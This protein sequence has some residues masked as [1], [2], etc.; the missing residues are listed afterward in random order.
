MTKKDNPL[1]SLVVPCYNVSFFVKKCIDSIKRQTYSNLEVLMIDDGSLDDT[2]KVI[3]ENIQDDKRFKYFYKENG[4]LSDARNYGLDK[5]RGEYISFIDSDDYL[6][7]NYVKKLYHTIIKYHVD[8]AVCDI[9]RIYDD[10][11]SVDGI[12]EIKTK[13]C[14]HPAVWNKL[15]KTSLFKDNKIYF[16]KG[17]WYEDLG[18]TPK[19]T[20]KYKYK[21][22][23]EP[24]YYYVQNTKSIMHTYDDR[25][26]QI[27]DII[28]DIEE[29]I[30]K[31]NLEEENHDILEFINVY[32]ILIGTIYRAASHP[33]FSNKMIKDIIKRVED[34]YPNWFRNKYLKTLRITYRMYLLMIKLHLVTLINILMKTIGRRLEL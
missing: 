10:H 23:E 30:K 4:G 9:K 26:F 14:M 27:Y 33:S 25:I 15:Y 19:L 20:L 22:I 17:S 16:P 24:L 3:K 13:L 11:E 12:N 7:K 8:I 18:T 5:T 1:I 31:E 28:N 21:V 29:Y 34:K 6:D 2:K 32:H